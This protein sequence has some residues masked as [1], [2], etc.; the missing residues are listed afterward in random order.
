MNCGFS[1]LQLH[2]GVCFHNLHPAESFQKVPPRPRPHIPSSFRV[3]RNG[4][5]WGGRVAAA[6]AI[7]LP[8]VPECAR[9]TP[10]RRCWAEVRAPPSHC[11]DSPLHCVCSARRQ[12]DYSTVGW[13]DLRLRVWRLCPHWLDVVEAQRQH[14]ARPPLGAQARNIVGALT[15]QWLISQCVCVW[16]VCHTFGLLNLPATE[17]QSNMVAQATMQ[18]RAN[19]FALESSSGSRKHKTLNATTRHTF[20]LQRN[21]A[22]KSTMTP[23]EC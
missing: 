3:G 5:W 11:P 10:R 13:T 17:L 6:G 16:R 7:V 19:I 23:I 22:M 2:G 4:Q 14:L 9:H 20:N 8:D 12:V 21:N 15:R 1:G 18:P